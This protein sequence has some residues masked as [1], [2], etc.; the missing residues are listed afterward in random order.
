MKY[1]DTVIYEYGASRS[2]WVKLSPSPFLLWEAIKRSKEQGYKMFDFGRT[3]NDNEGLSTFKKR[4]NAKQK[5]L[6]YYYLPDLG[7]FN[8]MRQKGL[9]KKLMY[10]TIKY[11][12]EPVCQLMGQF[13]YKNFV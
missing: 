4:W 9:A 5:T 6:H 3:E 1:K 10:H 11:S 12:P 13:L 8:S 7:G 2:E